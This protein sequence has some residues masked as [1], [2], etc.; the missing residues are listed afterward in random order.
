MIKGKVDPRQADQAL[1]GQG[2]TPKASIS[3]WEAKRRKEVALATL[4]ELELQERQGQ[5][6]DRN[7]IVS[8][9][10]KR[11]IEFKQAVLR[12][13]R[14][15]PP[16]LHNKSMQDMETIVREHCHACLKHLARGPHHPKAKAP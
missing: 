9:L 4:R 16:R 11:E 1:S 8:A 15:L 12:L 5:L 13:P 3:F 14:T 7:A 2:D 6:L 10:V